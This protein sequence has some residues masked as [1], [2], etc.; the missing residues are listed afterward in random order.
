MRPVQY[1]EKHKNVLDSFLLENPRVTPGT[2]YGH[3]AYYVNGKLFASLH[4]DGVCIKVPTALKEVLLKHDGIVPFE[5]MGRTMREWVLIN[6]ERSKDYR[7]DMDIFTASIE[8]VGLLADKKGWPAAGWLKNVD[9]VG[10]QPL[11]A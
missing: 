2:M 5:P 1:N 3:P 8:Y 6:R 9:L 4:R 7:D 11:P 10:E